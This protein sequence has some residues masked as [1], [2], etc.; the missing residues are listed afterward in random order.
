MI[1]GEF[2]KNILNELKTDNEITKYAIKAMEE[3]LFDKGF[4]ESDIIPVIAPIGRGAN[5]ET[6]NI[7]ADSVAGAIA[8]AIAAHKLIML[9]DVPG[10]LDKDGKLISQITVAQAEKLMKNKTIT[11]GMIPKIETCIKAV[12]NHTEAAHILDGRVPHA[13][14]LE[15]FTAHGTGTMMLST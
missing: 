10:L 1:G 12:T 6:Y 11:G 14:L 9:T 8:S 15:I 2:G 13:L 4:E 7:N 3:Q 5:G